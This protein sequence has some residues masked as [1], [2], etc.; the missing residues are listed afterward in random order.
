VLG[1]FGDDP[2]RFADAKSRRNYAGTSPLTIASGKKRA[3]LARHARNQRLYDAIDA[4]AFCSLQ[5]SPGARALYDQ[6]R[7]TGDT[8]HQALRALGNRWV[9]ILHGCLKHRTPYNEHT[10]WAH[11]QPAAA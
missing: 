11:R 4:W 7:G 2:E 1:E 6:R 5:A 9:G 3:V 8:H 10:A